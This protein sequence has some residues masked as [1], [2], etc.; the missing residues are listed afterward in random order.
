M[1]NDPKP[2]ENIKKKEKK[3]LSLVMNNNVEPILV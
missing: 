1:M 3:R 2:Y